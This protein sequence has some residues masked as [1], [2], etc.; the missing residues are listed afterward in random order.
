MI[1][2]FRVFSRWG[3]IVFEKENFLP[4]DALSSWD[5]KVRGKAATPDI[6]VYI[7]EILCEKG[8]PATFKGNVAILK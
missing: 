2:S 3:E 5:G 8:L 7:C 1:K 6:F 4:G